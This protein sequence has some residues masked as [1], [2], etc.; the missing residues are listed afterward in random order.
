ML[1]SSGRSGGGASISSSD[2]GTSSSASSASSSS[3]PASPGG[4]PNAG[5]PIKRPAIAARACRPCNP[6][7]SARPPSTPRVGAR[8]ESARPP[9]LRV[10]TAMPRK[11]ARGTTKDLPGPGVKN[12]LWPPASAQPYV[13]SLAAPLKEVLINKV[14]RLAISTSGGLPKADATLAVK[15]CAESREPALTYCVDGRVEDCTVGL[16][17]NIRVLTNRL[18]DMYRGIFDTAPLLSW[19]W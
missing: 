17:L 8:K 12:L 15:E 11:F 19:R 6:R 10:C 13:C 14:G 9:K 1:D 5:M 18:T 4:G 16:L 2:S 3:G 7:N